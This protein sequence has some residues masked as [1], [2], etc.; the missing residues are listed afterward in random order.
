MER[1]KLSR[2]V[3]R[4]LILLGIAVLVFVFGFLIK[5]SSRVT[6]ADA[7]GGNV[8]GE[9][10]NFV[11]FYDDGEKLTVKTDASIHDNIS[12]L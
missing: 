9:G 5:V 10:V 4:A 6:F 11:T 8:S 3:E 1:M 7:T 2:K 12:S